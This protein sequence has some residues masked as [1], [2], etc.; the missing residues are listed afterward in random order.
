MV[1]PANPNTENQLAELAKAIAHPTRIKIIRLLA[2]KCCICGELVD[3]F[4]Y[5]QATISQH[6]KVLKEAGLI[7]GEV[8]G[9]RVCY[10]LVRTRLADLHRLFGDLLSQTNSCCG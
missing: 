7:E 3:E 8:S 10:Q 9:P 6:L 4:P 1:Q 2:G 5:S